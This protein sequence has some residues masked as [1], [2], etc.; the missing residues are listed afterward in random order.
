MEKERQSH[1][2]PSPMPFLLF[3]DARHRPLGCPVYRSLLKAVE[4]LG[5]ARILKAESAGHAVKH[6][7]RKK[8]VV[9]WVGF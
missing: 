1:L 7:S 9:V 3:D 2:F 8:N 5:A 4:P 6:A